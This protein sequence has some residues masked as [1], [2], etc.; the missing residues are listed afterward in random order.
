ML[1]R[2]SWPLDRVNIR[3]GGVITCHGAERSLC[4]FRGGHGAR[5]CMVYFRSRGGSTGQTNEGARWN[6]FRPRFCHH[7]ASSPS[8]LYIYLPYLF[9]FSMTLVRM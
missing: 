8:L 4:C 7:A 6:H 9:S 3:L 2:K 5:R 1:K